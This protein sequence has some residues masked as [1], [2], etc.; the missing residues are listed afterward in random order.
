MVPK[1]YFPPSHPTAEEWPYIYQ[2]H[3]GGP[4]SFLSQPITASPCSTD[5]TL[6][7]DDEHLQAD[8]Y[9]LILS[10]ENAQQSSNDPDSPSAHRKSPSPKSTFNPHAA[11]FV[12]TKSSLPGCPVQSNAR[13]P[14][15]QDSGPAWLNSFWQGATSTLPAEQVSYAKQV[16]EKARSCLDILD[17]ARSFSS[18]CM[19]PHTY[20]S[21]A[22]AVYDTLNDTYGTW[23]SSRFRFHLQKLALESFHHAWSTVVYQNNPPTPEVDYLPRISCFVAELHAVGLF[24]RSQMHRCFGRVLNEMPSPEHV[25]VLWEMVLRAKETPWQGPGSEQLVTDFL[26]FFNERTQ[27]ILTTANFGGDGLVSTAAQA[28]SIPHVIREWHSQPSRRPLVIE[29]SLWAYP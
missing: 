26:H 2:T 3:N 11:P 20:A 27:L 22:R 24:P 28:S 16:A 6:V 17:L 19:I 1:Q 29:K 8:I 14:V 21:F 9:R 4:D 7:N 12:P 13:A 18:Q 23:E 5:A 10:P 15:A 25:H